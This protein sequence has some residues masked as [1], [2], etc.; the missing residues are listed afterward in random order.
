MQ[1]QSRPPPAIPPDHVVL[2][3]RPNTEDPD[4]V[5]EIS[6][7]SLLSMSDQDLRALL[8]HLGINQPLIHG[9]SRDKMIGLVMKVALSAKDS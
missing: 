8:D 7:E 6:S 9:W 4:E 3:R 5:L 2:E 1:V